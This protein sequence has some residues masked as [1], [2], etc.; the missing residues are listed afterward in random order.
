[1]NFNILTALGLVRRYL[2]IGISLSTSQAFVTAWLSPALPPPSVAA[3]WCDGVNHT[4]S[5]DDADGVR[6]ITSTAPQ[7]RSAV[8]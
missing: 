5:I 3:A 4:S 8:L 7:R 2:F 6:F 1:M